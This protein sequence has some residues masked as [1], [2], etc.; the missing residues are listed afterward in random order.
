VEL[1]APL[2]Y[3]YACKQG[4]QDADAADVSQEVL[5]AIVGSIGRLEYDPARGAFRNWLFTIVRSKLSTFLS[6]RH[7]ICRGTGDSS[8]QRLLDAQPS[9]DE[10]S[11]VWEAEYEQRLFVWATEQVRALDTALQNEGVPH[12]FC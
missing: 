10:D 1:Y 8:T 12:E 7:D 9:P 4:L 5:G 11:A 2:V 3:G 6:R